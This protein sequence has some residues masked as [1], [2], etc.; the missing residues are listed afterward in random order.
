MA[1]TEWELVVDTILPNP[2]QAAFK[3]LDSQAERL[4]SILDGAGVP[5]A[6]PLPQ[7]GHLVQVQA[8]PLPSPGGVAGG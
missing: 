6:F 8:A 5:F 4:K 3:F 1:A 2:V 7:L